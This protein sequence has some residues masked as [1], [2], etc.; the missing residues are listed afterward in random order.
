MNYKEWLDSGNL[1]LLLDREKTVGEHSWQASRDNM[2]TE[3]L[4]EIL[5]KRGYTCINR[6]ES[7]PREWFEQDFSPTKD[8][9]SGTATDRPCMFEGIDKTKATSLSCPC[10]KCSPQY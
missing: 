10:P 2:T 5:D 8:Y 7:L 3:E 6:V 9:S 1:D 4:I